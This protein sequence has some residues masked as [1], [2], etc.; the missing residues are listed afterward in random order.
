[1]ASQRGVHRHPSGLEHFHARLVAG[2]FKGGAELDLLIEAMPQ[3]CRNGVN[4]G[5]RTMPPT[6]QSVTL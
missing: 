4:E 5:P 1:M 3:R 2:L 6:H